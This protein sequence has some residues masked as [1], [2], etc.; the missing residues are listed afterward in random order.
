MVQVS[1]SENQINM[2][3]MKEKGKFIPFFKREHFSCRNRSFLNWGIASAML[4]MTAP[5]FASGSNGIFE[6]EK[7]QEVNQSKLI[8]GVVLDE[9]NDPLI[10]VTVQV[11]G[12]SIGTITNLSGE[13]SLNVPSNAT[14]LVS[15]IGYKDYSVKVGN[16]T[17]IKIELQPDNKVLDEV[18]VVG[19]ATV[20]KRDLTGAISSVKSDVNKLTPSSNPMEALQGRVAG[21]DITKTSGRAGEGVNMQL[22]GNR[23]I[24]ASGN[25]LF[26]IDGMPGDYSTL[27]PNDIESIEVLKDA[28]STAVYGSSGANGVVIITTKKGETGKLSINLNTYVGFNGWSTTP[29]MNNAEQWVYTRLLAQKE[30]GVIL[31]DDIMENCSRISRKRRSY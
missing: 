12:T 17:N 20:K 28:S 1:L 25:P 31:D 10:G 29:K 22:R 9:M 3:N 13:F 26:I 7:L 16:L 14:L 15:Y 8:S 19:Y 2:K 21:L 6:T 27:N 30:G 11:K 23:S 24:T 5:A 18:V 4:F